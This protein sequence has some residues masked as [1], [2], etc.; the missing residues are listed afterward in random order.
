MAYFR[1]KISK[2]ISLNENYI[3]LNLSTPNID[4]NLCDES[5]S[6]DNFKISFTFYI[7]ALIYIFD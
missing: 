1:Y 7:Y 2:I 6:I 4:N 5:W 3:D